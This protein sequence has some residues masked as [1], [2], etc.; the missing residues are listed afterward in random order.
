MSEAP[1]TPASLWTLQELA[2]Y[3]QRS[4]RWISYRLGRTPETEGSIPH[5]R[6]GRTPRFDPEEIR[7]WVQAGCP[8]TAVFR[9]APRDFKAKGGVSCSR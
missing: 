1:V 5:V 3:L 2:T 9:Q 4:P 7:A 6:L 8:S